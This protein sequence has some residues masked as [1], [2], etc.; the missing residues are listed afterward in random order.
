MVLIVGVLAVGVYFGVSR[1]M[2]PPSTATPAAQ[3][4]KTAKKATKTTPKVQ[5]KQQIS[6][7]A[8]GDSLT[9]G[10]GDQAEGGYVG[11]IKQLLHKKQ[12]LTVHTTN[13]GKAGDRSDQILARINQSDQLQAKIAK[14]DVVTV[15]VGGN[16][17]LQTLE[18]TL[19]SNNTA[20]N[21]AAV[22][23]AQT[24]YA[25][26]LVKLFDRLHELNPKAPL[27]VFSIYNP[28]FVNFPNV[29]SITRYV[30]RW[31]EQTETILARYADA[32]FMDINTAM[33]HGQYKTSAQLKRLKRSADE[34]TITSLSNQKSVANV[35][36]AESKTNV[37]IST[38]DNFHP[39]K[40]GYGIFSQKLYQTMMAHDQW[41]V[42]K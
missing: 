35:L 36:A 30:S 24:D 25:N 38:T 33:S 41:A 16:D 19:G 12:N 27:F 3:P 5:R 13:A 11:Q 17:L 31:N 8:V 34:S 2:S 15:T 40:R 29:T 21:N 22:A 18:K 6:L 4:T 1:L 32:H 39:N 14:A 23:K 20:K 10:I 28:I 9:E 37:L 42:K 7:V 26:K